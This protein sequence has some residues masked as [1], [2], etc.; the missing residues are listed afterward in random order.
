MKIL[1]SGKTYP[2]RGCS[3]EA[4]ESTWFNHKQL[5]HSWCLSCHQRYNLER[6]SDVRWDAEEVHQWFVEKKKVGKVN[7]WARGGARSDAMK[8]KPKNKQ[9]YR[10]H[11][12]SKLA[13]RLTVD[14]AG[15][16]ASSSADNEQ[17]R[18]RH[19][20]AKEVELAKASNHDSRSHDFS[21]SDCK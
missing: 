13:E 5:L 1:S 19:R 3:T 4:D 7:H 9:A 18:K 6:P 16:A 8:A 2:C 17:D 21:H 12:V 10:E 15:N 20:A 11:F 14:G